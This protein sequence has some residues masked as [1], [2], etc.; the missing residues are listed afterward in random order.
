LE[1]IAQA[2]RQQESA[3]EYN[4]DKDDGDD[5]SVEESQETFGAS[6]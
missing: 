1:T 3:S 4:E 2:N 5:F 6:L